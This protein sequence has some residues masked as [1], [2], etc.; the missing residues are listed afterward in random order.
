MTSQLSLFSAD[1]S[2]PAVAD[3]AGLLCGHGQLARF[4][5]SAARL[6]VVVDAQWRADAIGVEL[7]AR[8]IDAEQARSGSGHPLVR[9]AFRQDLAP[10]A[11]AWTRGAMKSVPAGCTFDG[12]MLRLWVLSGGRPAERGG[13]LF[14]LDPRAP[15]THRPLADA[16]AAVGLRGVLRGPRATPAVQVTGKRRLAQLAVLIGPPPP[17]AG[18][19]WPGG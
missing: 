15:D 13:Y 11:A 10:L 18:A 19:E 7:Q 1:A 8:G 9:T 12:S 6:S 4:A 14:D 16:L 17:G 2:A 5:G 3:L